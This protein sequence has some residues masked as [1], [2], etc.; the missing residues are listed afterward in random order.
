MFSGKLWLKKRF[1]ILPNDNFTWIL[2]VLDTLCVEF[3]DIYF[4]RLLRYS[5]QEKLVIIL[6]SLVWV[7]FLNTA[8]AV[9]QNNWY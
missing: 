4:S 9:F 2:P 1:Q 6:S 3:F 5:L 8:E 7:L